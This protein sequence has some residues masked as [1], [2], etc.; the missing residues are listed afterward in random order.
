MALLQKEERKIL[1]TAIIAGVLMIGGL[2]VYLAMVEQQAN[3]VAT[4]KGKKITLDDYK[5]KVYAVTG[6]GTAQKPTGL[7]Q[8]IKEPLLEE[9]IFEK[10]AEEELKKNGLKITEAEIEKKSKELNSKY[11][12]LGNREKSAIDKQAAFK[13]MIEKLEN[14]IVTWREGQYLLCRYDRYVQSDMAKTPEK[15]QELKQ[16]QE[17]YSEEYCK[18]VK[19]RI[20][21]GSSDYQTEKKKLLE[22]PVIGNA[23]WLPFSMTLAHEFNQENFG[24]DQFVIG[25]DLRDKILASNKSKKVSDP[26]KIKVVKGEN[27][28]EKIDGA[29]A[30]ILLENKGKD[31][32]TIN[33]D[34]YLEESYQ[35]LSK[36]GQIKKF[37]ER[38]KL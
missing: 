30:V 31:G 36:E 4:V 19:E 33:L 38:I 24:S 22:D 37:E 32:S 5:S 13:V 16:K 25:S 14:N 15:A 27:E 20:A 3:T 26:V 7:D 35:K 12:T 9:L 18:G 21:S 1:I 17:K 10:L 23:S 6:E 34:K 8:Y 29:F 2:L 28:K 11:S